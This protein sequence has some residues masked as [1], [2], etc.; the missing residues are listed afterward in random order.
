VAKTS[1]LREFQEAILS[2]LKDAASQVGGESLSRLGVIVGDKR[3][4]I[5]LQDVKEVLPVPPLQLV[6]FTKPW[7]L[8]VAN[9]RGNLYSISDLA[10]FMGM[11]PTP[12]AVN[13]RILL[14]STAST[15]QVAL[16]VD[17]LIGL[18]SIQT[19]QVQS[20]EDES[21]FFS[22]NVYIDTEGNDWLELD[23]EALVQSK[24]FVQP[25]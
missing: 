8:G 15:E 20:V 13:N 12:R 7:F 18:R 23:V 10:Q 6:P 22:L 5:N 9:V 16:L 4:L 3:F 21:S 14:L 1:N 11:Q 19:M 2:K 17:S 25:T 24:S